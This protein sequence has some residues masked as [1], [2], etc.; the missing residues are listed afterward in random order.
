MEKRE[1]YIKQKEENFA[2]YERN[3][4]EIEV[5][6]KGQYVAI[7][8]G[9]LLVC[10]GTYQEALEKIKSS[11]SEVLHFLIFPAE[12]GPFKGIIKVV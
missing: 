8:Q 12:K 4:R 6:Y 7:A 10:T 11:T 5:K 1:L 2:A 9:K 3:K